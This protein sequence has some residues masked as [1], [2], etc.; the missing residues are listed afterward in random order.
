MPP[1]KKTLRR[2][3][4]ASPAASRKSGG[5]RHARPVPA[6]ASG[7]ADAWNCLH[8]ID[9]LEV[10]PV[11]LE[12]H[13]LV[14]PYTL[15]RKGKAASTEHIYRYEEEVFDPSDPEGLALARMM[16]AQI[17]I[18]YG[19]FCEEIVF[20]GDY[21][22]ADRDFIEK[23]MENTSREIA[24][25]KFLQPNPFLLGPAASLPVVRPSR[26]THAR[27]RFT[28]ES[29]GTAPR[30]RPPSNDDA[31]ATA[32]WS[33]RQESVAV[34]SSGGKDSLLSFG[35][36][37]EIG[38]E[39]HPIF[40]NESGNHWLTA[41][42]AYKH[43]A[44]EHPGTA[45]VWT[46]SD[47]VF[48][49]FKRHL[50]FIRPDF[51]SVRADDY[52]I[53]LWTVAVF[54]F[55]ALPLLRKRGIGRLVIGDEYDTTRR[56]V[57]QGI[58]H[59]DGLYDQSRFFDRELSRYFQ[60]RG[61][62]VRQF[63]LLRPLSEFLVQKILARRYPDL[64]VH[65]VSC[66]AAHLE[67]G[68]VR[69]CGKC[70][71]CRRIVGMLVAST[72]DPAL[73]GYTPAQVE[74]CL[75]ALATAGVHQEADCASHVLYVLQQ[76]GRLP[77]GEGVLR[78]RS[79]PEVMQL[80][81]DPERSPLDDIPEDL[82]ERLLRIY[83]S[84]AKGAV[85][86]EGRAWVR[87][88][89]FVEVNR[90]AHPAGPQAQP[91]VGPQASLLVASRAHDSAESQARHSVG[92]QAPPDQAKPDG[93]APERSPT[94]ERFLW[95]E[96]TWPEAKERL[97]KVDVALLPVGAI[98][99]HGPHLPLDTDSYDAEH[100]GREVAARCKEPRPLV[101]PLIPYGVS[102]HHEDFA[103]TVSIGPETLSRLVYEIGMNL[104][105]QGITK[106]IVLNGHGG[107]SPAL[108]FAAQL[109]NRDA[110]IFTCVDTGETSDAD[111]NSMAET[112]NDVHAGEIET[113]TTL[114]TRPELVRLD[115][116]RK[117]VPK[118]SSDY[119]DFTSKRSI[120][121]YA[122]TARLSS[123]GVLG[124]PTKASRE[125]GEKMWEVM[126]RNLVELVEHLKGMSLDEIYQTRY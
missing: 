114:A 117:L 61:W 60:R 7:G 46:N 112:P 81:L 8:V 50:P 29:V 116:A 74:N 89:A 51:L 38:Q 94:P 73:C 48:A 58:S 108:H 107:N 125:K 15:I 21:D 32:G 123:S 106:L 99:Q 40:I 41:R 121:W 24:V 70:E 96:L 105:R 55:G 53:R 93:S 4:V 90:A 47:R 122:R 43:L 45:R 111:V 126:V 25:K 62:G 34:L 6:A 33:A 57:F 14:T 2:P 66:H 1:K 91:S 103:G 44:V 69:P 98:E 35:L 76:K 22:A 3:P 65:Q 88:D 10:G 63:S 83:L 87:C 104:A 110:H 119:L 49:W 102:Y 31:R 11:R 86:R 67:D 42:N 9:R 77:A 36:L 59:Y 52:P 27:L 64:F 72:V 113:S 79:H 37:R 84:H 71:K 39:L 100:L 54:L 28:N 118:F 120:T 85:R 18:N 12:P 97:R 13:R 75:R 23:M 78:P 92:P 109:I 68:R 95:G 30:R 17:A 56:A 101:L 82:Q 20:H 19:L 26:W 16:A 124:D 5:R 80:R 115:K